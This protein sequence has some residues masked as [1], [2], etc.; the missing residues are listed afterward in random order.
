M[1]CGSPCEDLGIHQPISAVHNGYEL[2]DGAY[3]VPSSGERIVAPKHDFLST[4]CD[5]D[6][7][8]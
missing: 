4:D 8:S 6:F 1:V 7:N 2:I 3:E 5:V